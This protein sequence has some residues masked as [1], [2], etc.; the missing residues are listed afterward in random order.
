MRTITTAKGSIV[1]LNSGDWVEN[2][3][4]LE[5]VRGEWT[6][7]KFKESDKADMTEDTKDDDGDLTHSQLFDNML[8]EFNLMRQ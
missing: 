7:F 5:Y 3:S 8:Q 2:L 6:I 1:Y 4:A